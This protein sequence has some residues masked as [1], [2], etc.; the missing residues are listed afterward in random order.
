M[1]LY[2]LILWNQVDI[3][4]KHFKRIMS[5]CA[6]G[7][8]FTLWYSKRVLSF[9]K[10]SNF[11]TLQIFQFLDEGMSLVPVS[12][13]ITILP[14]SYIITGQAADILQYVA[15]PLSGIYS[16]ELKVSI[17]VLSIGNIMGM[18]PCCCLGLC[19]D[20]GVSQLGHA[21]HYT[22]CPPLGVGGGEEGSLPL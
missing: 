21:W 13:D 12:K 16:A 22:D 5:I 17:G 8:G 19:S 18:S 7:R 3:L 20:C 15:I 10:L 11:Q 14:K 4:Q 9:N 2:Y 6:S 1:S